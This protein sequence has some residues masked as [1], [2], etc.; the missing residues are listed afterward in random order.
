M[1]IAVLTALLSIALV[2]YFVKAL[3]GFGPAIVFVSL[4]SLLASP[5]DIII[6]SVILDIAGG[7]YLFLLDRGFEHFK[8]LIALAVPAVAGTFLGVISLKI[9]PVD[10]FEAI[11]AIII[12]ILGL[13]F[14]I[15]F[16][17][18]SQISVSTDVP[19]LPDCKGLICAAIGGITGGLFGISGP[20]IIWYF[21]HR[22]SKQ[23]VRKLLV[24]LFLIEACGRLA[25][26][27]SF[28]LVQP[29]HIITAGFIV[30]ALFV[31]LIAGN[32][33]HVKISEKTFRQII[34]FILIVVSIKMFFQS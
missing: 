5:K 17:S 8:Y 27:F 21:G 20:P 16:Q 4:G 24:P 15:L 34:G 19:R 11:L 2:A 29:Q 1:T 22:Y 26:Y 23:T 3:T 10:I 28:D 30:P 12:F 6:I 13:W 31:G 9:V 33:M 7:I 25:L 32:S 18:R 14:L